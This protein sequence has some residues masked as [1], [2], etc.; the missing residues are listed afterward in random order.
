MMKTKV[1]LLLLISVMAGAGMS[2]G[3][4]KVASKIGHEVEKNVNETAGVANSVSGAST[5]KWTLA[6]GPAACLGAYQKKIGQDFNILDFS[7]YYVKPETIDASDA[8][9]YKGTKGGEMKTCDLKIQDPAD[10]KKAVG[11]R[12]DM[13]TGEISGPMPVEITV[14]GNAEAFKLSEVVYPVKDIDY[15]AIQK[16]IDSIKPKLD[17]KY[18]VYQVTGIRMDSDLRTGKPHLLVHIDGKLKAND[19]AKNVLLQL[20]PDGKKITMNSMN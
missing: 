15:A 16:N 14:S 1:K 5:Y 8:R 13:K 2:T 19:V 18:G 7:T 17:E 4:G 6:D 12:M 10:P 3:C 11:Y 20:T 9:N